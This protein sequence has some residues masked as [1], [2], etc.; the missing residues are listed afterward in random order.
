MKILKWSLLAVLVTGLGLSTIAFLIRSPRPLDVDANQAT[1]ANER[2][3]AAEQDQPEVYQPA[4]LAPVPVR[5]L[6]PVIPLTP[7]KTDVPAAD[8]APEPANVVQVRADWM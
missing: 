1:D 3:Q 7:D 4:P 5:K 2:N 8:I 6:A